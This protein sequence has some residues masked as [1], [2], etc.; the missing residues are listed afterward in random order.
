MSTA[1]CCKIMCE[2]CFNTCLK[3]GS[4]D[5]KLINF[6]LQTSAQALYFV[7]YLASLFVVLIKVQNNSRILCKVRSWS[8]A[9]KMRSRSSTDREKRHMVAA[10]LPTSCFSPWKQT[11]VELQYTGCICN[12]DLSESELQP[13]IPS[14]QRG[15]GQRGGRACLLQIQGHGWSVCGVKVDNRRISTR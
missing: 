14:L 3:F 12:D 2:L 15:G 13:R 9:A 8:A 7:I 6:D 4:T 1:L 5:S 10:R 11:H